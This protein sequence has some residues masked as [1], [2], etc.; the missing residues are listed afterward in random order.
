MFV[1]TI[2]LAVAFVS[3]VSVGFADVSLDGDWE[4]R[5]E[6]GK[7]VVKVPNFK[8]WSPEHPNLHTV[9]LSA[10]SRERLS[11]R[12]GIRLLDGG[13]LRFRTSPQGLRRDRPPL[14]FA[15]LKGA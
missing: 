7:A 13:S 14:L 2:L 5:F 1:K 10:F 15:A 6:D 9:A 8:L 12:F 4:F 11:A 3:A